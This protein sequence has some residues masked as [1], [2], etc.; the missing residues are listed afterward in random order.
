MT[1][2]NLDGNIRK[3]SFPSLFPPSLS[4]SQG[5]DQSFGS[6]KPHT[7]SHSHSHRVQSLQFSTPFPLPLFKLSPN[8]PLLHSTGA[9]WINHSQCQCKQATPPSV[10]SANSPHYWER[11]GSWGG[12]WMEE[13]FG[14]LMFQLQ[15]PLMGWHALSLRTLSPWACQ[16][17]PGFPGPS[18]LSSCSASCT[19]LLFPAIPKPMASASSVSSHSP[20]PAVMTGNKNS[21]PFSHSHDLSVPKFQFLCVLCMWVF[22]FL[23][24]FDVINSIWEKRL[25]LF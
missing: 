6:H 1:H 9:C 21:L 20:S 14:T 18:R 19:P 17:G 2:E 23:F 15:R 4:I 3:S 8:S 7:V 10:P 16:E 24:N 12:L 11:W 22:L 5:R 13:G 25:F